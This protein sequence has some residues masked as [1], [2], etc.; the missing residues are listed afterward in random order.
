M[1]TSLDLPTKGPIHDPLVIEHQGLRIRLAPDQPLRPKRLI[2]RTKETGLIKLAWD[3]NI[4]TEEV[5]QVLP[6]R[7]PMSI[8]LEGAP[9]MGK[10]ALIE[11]CASKLQGYK[12]YSIAG[13]E[14]LEPEDLI[15]SIVPSLD[16]DKRFELHASPLLT[17]LLTPRSIFFF[18]EINRV[19]ERS[20]SMLSSLLD[21]RRAMYSGL[22]SKWFTAATRNP[23]DFI[24][25]AA[26]NKDGARAL[27]EYIDQRLL[28][29]ITVGRPSREEMMAIVQGACATDDALMDR[30]FTWYIAKG[31]DRTASVRQCL[32]LLEMAKRDTETSMDDLARSFMSD[33][34]P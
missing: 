10:N 7:K 12:F 8:K 32:L 21:H 6:G 31:A 1:P 4:A 13:H 23:G 16:A 14:Q 30:F 2:G 18:D 5:W 25:C 33:G 17:A 11:H 29:T 15:L 22:V 9:G 3:V 28:P 26:L 20:L 19:P 27:P 34:N 24:F